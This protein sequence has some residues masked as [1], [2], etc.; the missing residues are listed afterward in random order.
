MVL[1]KFNIYMYVAW[2]KHAWVNSTV[3]L[4]LPPLVSA[5][6]S[7]DAMRRVATMLSVLTQT[8]NV[9]ND[10]D[11][12]SN[13]LPV[14]A[15]E[16]FASASRMSS[17]FVNRRRVFGC[18]RIDQGGTVSPFRPPFDQ[19]RNINAVVVCTRTVSSRDLYQLG[20]GSL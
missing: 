1:N 13:F 15:A 12:H 17:G 7:S 16:P 10:I 20:C 6:A 2:Q 5:S 4:T 8:S 3:T 19:T 14:L 11:K 9:D 18:G